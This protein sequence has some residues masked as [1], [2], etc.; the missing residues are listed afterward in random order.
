MKILVIG[1]GGREH[2]LCWRLHANGHEVFALPGSA[3]IATVATCIQGDIGDQPAVE[4]AA[5]ELGVELVVI[6]P[7]V[8]LVAGLAD[9][10]RAAGHAVFGPSAAAAQLEGSKAFSK[11][12]FERHGIPTARFFECTTMAAA[13]QAIASL[14]GRVVVKADGLA[15]GKGVVVCSTAQQAQ[16]AAR[17]MLEEGRFASA[18]AKIIVEQRL[19][20]REVS[21][22]ALCDGKRYELLAAAEDHKA[23]FDGDRGPNTG[24]MGTVSPVEWVSDELVERARREVFDRTL[25]GLQADGLDFRGVLYAGLMVDA[26]GTPWLLEYNVRFGDPETQ[27]V[28][29]RIADD[30]GVWLLACAQ[31]H[32]PDA[33]L[34]WD[35]RTAVCV[36]L[37]SAGYPESA[38]KGDA[39]TGLEQFAEPS[40]LVIFHAGSKR[41]GNAFVTDGGRVL[42]V[43]GLGEGL[44]KARE[45]VYAA[46]DRIQFSGMQFRRDIGLRGETHV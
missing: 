25:R 22:M 23:I 4:R 20:G 30:L 36:V 12:F 2:A 39:I 40:E 34:R 33:Q 26:E 8:P 38:R 37:A 11:R 29:L 10:L 42:A 41:S 32:M 24:G 1:A 16:S 7:E 19:E 21:M 18:G 5:R 31:G 43:T 15:A 6:G 9:S 3:G 27:P 44:T 35:P 28:M 14:G 13:D 17:E 46:V 45:K